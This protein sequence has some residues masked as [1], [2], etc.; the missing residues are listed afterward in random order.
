MNSNTRSGILQL[1]GLN[2]TTILG[3]NLAFISAIADLVVL[4]LIG[5]GAIHHAY[6]GIVAFLLL[7]GI[8]ILGSLLI[9]FGIWEHKRQKMTLSENTKRYPIFDFNHPMTRNVAWLLF[10]LTIGNMIVI[11]VLT[12]EGVAYTSSNNFCGAV[13]HTPMEPQF[14]AFKNSS[15]A[16]INCIDCHVESGAAGFATA[17]LS[18]VGQLYEALTD[19]FDRPIISPRTSTAPV[20]DSCLRCHS[21]KAD[22]A[23]FLDVAIRY[24]DDEQNTLD[25]SA[26]VF[27][28]GTLA[29]DSGIHGWHNQPGRTIE[30]APSQKEPDAIRVVRVT[31]AEGDVVEYWAEEQETISPHD[32]ITMTCIDCHNRVGHRFVMLA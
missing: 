27:T 28:M 7:P 25:Q 20:N 16:G 15:H 29:T 6:V 30:Y 4:V 10:L 2:W 12:F 18:G 11:T 24:S 19:N 17:K 13:C 21:N 5:I 1:L 31:E 22:R 26:L 14:T 3:S 32:W 8:F 9:I 23:Q